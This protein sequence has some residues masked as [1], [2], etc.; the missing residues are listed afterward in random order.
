MPV[1]SFAFCRRLTEE[2]TIWSIE[3]WC[4]SCA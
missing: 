1:T 2:D 3:W 4:E